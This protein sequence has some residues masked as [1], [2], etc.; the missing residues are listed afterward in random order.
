M[1]PVDWR[2]PSSGLVTDPILVPLGG[3]GANQ[4]EILITL[5]PSEAVTQADLFGDLGLVRVEFGSDAQF[6]TVP[7]P[8][9]LAFLCLGGLFLTRIRRQR[10]PLKS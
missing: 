4:V 2:A 6:I 5:T 8:S 10:R 3:L 9:T 7:E 1:R